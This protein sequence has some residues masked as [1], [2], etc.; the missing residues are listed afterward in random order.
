MG[1]IGV[2]FRFDIGLVLE[3]DVHARGQHDSIFI[4]GEAPKNNE[5]HIKLFKSLAAKADDDYR[6]FV[7]ENFTTGHKYALG[8]PIGALKHMSDSIQ[9]FE[10]EQTKFCQEHHHYEIEDD[11]KGGDFEQ[12]LW[13]DCDGSC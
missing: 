8:L 13:F 9:A 2:L 11:L 4:G 3:N 5:S 12:N 1:A 6:L 7:E 10:R